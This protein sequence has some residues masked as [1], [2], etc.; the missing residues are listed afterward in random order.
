M[1]AL[2]VSPDTPASIYAVIH[3]GVWASSNGGSSW[4]QVTETPPSAFAFDP[5]SASTLYAGVR[6]TVMKSTDGGKSWRTT[7]LKRPAT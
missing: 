7:R 6:G 5:G 4:T 1:A 3:E 2:V